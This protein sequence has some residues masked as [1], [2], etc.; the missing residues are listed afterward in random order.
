METFYLICVGLGGSLIVLQALA[1]LLGIGGDHGDHGFDHDVSH[2][3]GHDGV[4]HTGDW[5]LG[6]LSFRTICSAVLFFGLGGM[7]ALYYDAAPV[8]ALFSA[9]VA[10]GLALY[11]VAQAMNGLVR[12]KA[13]GTVRVNNAVGHTGTVY[14]RVPANKTG[15]G[16]VTLN[17][18]NRT[19]ELEA[20][21]SS[22]ELP[23]GTPIQVV[24][25][26]NA[27]SVEVSRVPTEAR[28]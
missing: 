19:V 27:N 22:D 1:S 20:Y 6:L 24:A 3:F 7:I 15:P 14:L 11:L 8:G 16:K 9:L 12:L 10:G 25:V 28:V 17:L 13:D 26:L 5:Y 2:D 4:A 21:T 23:T 18:Q